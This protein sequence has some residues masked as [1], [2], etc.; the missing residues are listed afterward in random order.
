MQFIKF[1][2]LVLIS[3]TLVGLGGCAGT[4]TKPQM[5]PLEIQS[6]QTRE[7][8]ATKKV[9]FASVVS[10]FQDIGY[11]IENA[12]YD[13][14]LIKSL[15]ATEN[16]AFLTFMTGATKNTQTAANAFV[17][18]I[19]GIVKVRLTF[20]TKTRSSSAYGAQD[21]RDVPILD[22]AAYQSAFEKIENA[23]FIRS[24]N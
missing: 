11:T 8:E 17:E 23:I 9:V 1:C 13:T 7:Y 16:S 20:V 6:L 4:S 14:G 21:Q 24:A 15:S 19:G 12:D 22:A 10:V 3:L 18:E 5:T 2:S